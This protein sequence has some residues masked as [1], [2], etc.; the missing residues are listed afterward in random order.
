MAP[1]ANKIRRGAALPDS[2][3]AETVTQVNNLAASLRLLTAKLDADVG[4][5]DT[6]YAALITESAIATAPAQITSITG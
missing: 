3:I 2:V 6:N 1:P 4:V 5:T